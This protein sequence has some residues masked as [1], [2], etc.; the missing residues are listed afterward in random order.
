[1]R[2]VLELPQRPALL[3]LH[4]Y[5]F[6]GNRTAG[7]ACYKPRMQVGR[8]VRQSEMERN[9]DDLGAYYSLPAV[10]VRRAF[11][12]HA[13]LTLTLTVTLTVTLTLTLTL[14]LSL[15]R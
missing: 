6:C 3:L 10:S 11:F 13:M 5:D 9:L 8:F 4:L 2:W 15:T 12:Q 7:S 14:T 1:M